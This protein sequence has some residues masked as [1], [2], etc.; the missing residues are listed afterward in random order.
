VV[1]DSDQDEID[2]VHLQQ[3]AMVREVMRQP[4]LSSKGLRFSRTGRGDR[5]QFRVGT[6]PEGFGMDRGNEPGPEEANFNFVV[7]NPN[8]KGHPMY[9]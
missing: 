4:M 3:L 1:G 2:F 9:G 5:Q 7:H 8:A 6:L